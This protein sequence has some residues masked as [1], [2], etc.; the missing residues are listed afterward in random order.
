MTL[1]PTPPSPNTATVAPGSD[2][3][4]VQH[5]ADASRY[6]TA[7][8]ADFFQRRLLVD[9]RN[10]DLGQNRVLAKRGG[11]HVVENGLAIV[12]EARCPV[13]HQS[14]ALSDTNCLAQIGFT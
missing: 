9:F 5:G 11:A 13:G 6:S 3:C 10:G 8:E 14:L 4:G 2:L 7:Q 1:R 12:R